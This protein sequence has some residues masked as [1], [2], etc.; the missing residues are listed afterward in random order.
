MA[1]EGNSHFYGVRED[2][3]RRLGRSIFSG[4]G[5][6]A[7]ATPDEDEWNRRVLGNY[8]DGDRLKTIPASRKKRWAILK[9]L[10]GKFEAGRR[11]RESEVNKMIQCH[12]W[13]S[14]TL[15]RELIGYRMLS[16][17]NAIY[18]RQSESEWMR[19]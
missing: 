17:E 6:L 7:H 3:L 18:W 4:C 13:D 2:Q 12:Y 15:R 14:A 19:A 9:W 5:A 8:L 16:R 1:R 11:Y 10:A